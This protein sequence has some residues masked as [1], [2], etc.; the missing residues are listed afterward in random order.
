MLI[1]VRAHDN[2]GCDDIEYDFHTIHICYARAD[3]SALAVL[4][5]VQLPEALSV[6]GD[7][8]LK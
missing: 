8:N 7:E 3:S 5:V 1:V 2:A 6:L 4:R